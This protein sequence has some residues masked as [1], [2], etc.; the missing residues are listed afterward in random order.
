MDKNT[1][2]KNKK[3]LCF[4]GSLSRAFDFY[5]IYILA[6]YFNQEKINIDILICGSGEK[7]NE[8]KRLMQNLEN[9]F[10]PGWIDIN[11]INVLFKTHMLC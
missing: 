5:P 2:E 1:S 9:V 3:I 10:F 11:K 7:D 4:V 8:I 6:K